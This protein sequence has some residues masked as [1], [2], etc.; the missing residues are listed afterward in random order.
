MSYK[1]MMISKKRTYLTQFLLGLLFIFGLSNSSHA[2][3][4]KINEELAF[5]Q[6]Q[7]SSLESRGK[8]ESP[9]HQIEL[10]VNQKY[11]ELLEF[12]LFVKNHEIDSE[13]ST[14]FKKFWSILHEDLSRDLEVSSVFNLLSWIKEKDTTSSRS[15]LSHP[16]TLI[17]K[18][19]TR[20][21]PLFFKYS[22]DTGLLSLKLHE[23]P[24]KITYQVIHTKNWSSWISMVPA[25]SSGKARQFFN[26]ELNLM[27]LILSLD[28]RHRAGLVQPIET[29][30]FFINLP[31]YSEDLFSSIQHS[32]SWTRLKQHQ[33]LALVSRVT[34]GLARLHSMGFAHFDIK[35]ENF[36]VSLDPDSGLPIDLVLTDFEFTVSPHTL[37]REDQILKRPDIGSL[38]Y[39]APHRELQLYEGEQSRALELSHLDLL[40]EASVRINPTHR[41]SSQTFLEGLQWIESQAVHH[42]TGIDI[43]VI[44]EEDSESLHSTPLL[45]PHQHENQGREH[46]IRYGSIGAYFISTEPSSIKY[47]NRLIFKEKD[48]NIRTLY[49]NPRST[50]KWQIQSELQFLKKLGFITQP[51]NFGSAPTPEP[52]VCDKRCG[53]L[54]QMFHFVTCGYFKSKALKE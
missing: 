4:L 28:L 26:A 32:K 36:L 22:P 54:S 33:K 17:H 48:S 24:R 53:C 41:I 50:T 19:P 44:N 7:I 15:L 3:S 21:T 10:R 9:S 1:L 6:S 37:I 40:L 29:H 8:H 2:T 30:E 34:Q 45:S 27:N 20:S 31:V 42:G 14:S 16:P 13:I 51:V 39:S 38:Q 11:E 23:S 43:D 49:L 5:V 18:T 46:L 25:R 52:E 12:L 35:P 47:R